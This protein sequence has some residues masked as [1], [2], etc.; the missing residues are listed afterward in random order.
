[1]NWIL[2]ATI[3]AAIDASIAVAILAA[4]L[5]IQSANLIGVLYTVLF[6]A[7]KAFAYSLI[8]CYAGLFI[9]EDCIR[10]NRQAKVKQ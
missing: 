7:P 2:I 1:M 10:F 9:L 6:V 4:W 5:Y 3:K 8:A